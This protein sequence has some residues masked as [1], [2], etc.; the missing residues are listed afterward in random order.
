MSIINVV[1]AIAWER[2][3]SCPPRELP[4]RPLQPLLIKHQP[5]NEIPYIANA[6]LPIR[7]RHRHNPPKP[8]ITDSITHPSSSLI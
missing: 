7:I 8:P 5:E 1:K 6:V 4:Q 2:D 3:N